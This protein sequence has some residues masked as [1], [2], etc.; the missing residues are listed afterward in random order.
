M[1]VLYVSELALTMRVTEKCDV[2]SF[3]VVAFEFTMGRHPGELLTSLQSSNSTSTS[4]DN[5]LL[6][7]KDILDER[8]L[9]PTDREAEQ[10]VYVLKVA[11]ACTRASP[12][13][14][15]SMRNV[16]QELSARS[17]L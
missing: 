5:L 8:L 14:R 1:F 11:L 12:E 6:L 9:P 16:A 2:Y 17:L 3:G 4:P 13:S 10:V 7:L 15:P